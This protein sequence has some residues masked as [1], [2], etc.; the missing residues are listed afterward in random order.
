[1]KAKADRFK[2]E[3]KKLEAKVERSLVSGKIGPSTSMVDAMRRE[4][5]SEANAMSVVKLLAEMDDLRRV[6]PS[7]TFEILVERDILKNGGT[8]NNG[9]IVDATATIRGKKHR[10][11]LVVFK[12]GTK[13]YVNQ[14]GTAI[15]KPLG[16]PVREGLK[17]YSSEFGM[18]EDPITRKV[19]MHKGLDI[20][21][22][23]G[24]P[25]YAPADGGVSSVDKSEG[26]GNMLCV[27]H[28]PWLETCYAHLSRADVAR[29]QI[30]MR[31]QIIGRVGNTGRSTGAHLHFE[32]IDNGM[33]VNPRGFMQA[34]ELPKE[35]RPAHLAAKQQYDA[36]KT[37]LAEAKAQKEEIRKTEGSVFVQAVDYAMSGEIMKAEAADQARKEAVEQIIPSV[38]S[39]L[40]ELP[41]TPS[42][43]FRSRVGQ[44]AEEDLSSDVLVV[45][46]EAREAVE[47]EFRRIK[48][49][50]AKKLPPQTIPSPDLACVRVNRAAPGPAKLAALTF[51]I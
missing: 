16:A 31:G 2:G 43:M 8:M 51:K 5:L 23:E 12:D 30:V 13:L 21:A 50:L 17:R 36:E 38:V 42:E 6:V 14:D 46:R 32:T 48:E 10:M 44:A 22:P 28:A 20:A 29:G 33:P 4:G 25:V 18:R 27:K 11:S 15:M 35:D 47:R 1:M 3:A 9:R 24:T 34:W 19:S 40:D 45:G 37:A 39:P 49:E 7:D 26:Y 41:A